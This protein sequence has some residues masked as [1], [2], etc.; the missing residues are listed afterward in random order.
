MYR[1]NSESLYAIYLKGVVDGLQMEKRE[2]LKN[3]EE[4]IEWIRNYDNTA[5]SINN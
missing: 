1:V 3:P 4:V 5:E 2:P